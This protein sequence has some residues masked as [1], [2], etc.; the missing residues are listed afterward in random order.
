MTEELE[1]SDKWPQIDRI[2]SQ[3]S[4]LT[5]LSDEELEA[6]VKELDLK[7]EGQTE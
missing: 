6:R 4:R 7:K 3:L 2:L 1:F 5:E